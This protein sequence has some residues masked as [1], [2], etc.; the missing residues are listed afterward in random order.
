MNFL[1]LL[2]NGGGVREL[3]L[4]LFLFIKTVFLGAI[5][6]EGGCFGNAKLLEGREGL[7]SV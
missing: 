4:V 6:K 5:E 3:D 2:E 7:N 1:G